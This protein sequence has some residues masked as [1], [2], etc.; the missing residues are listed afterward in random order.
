MNKHSQIGSIS[1]FFL[2]V[3]LVV[4][5]LVTWHLYFTIKLHEY[6]DSQLRAIPILNQ[7]IKPEYSVKVNP[8]NNLI[9]ITFSIPAV[10]SADNPLSGIGVKFW[11]M[12]IQAAG[13]ELIEREIN[14][15]ARER[16]N[17][18]AV[19]IPYRV[20]INT[21]SEVDI[22]TNNTQNDKT[23]T[24]LFN[25]EQAEIQQLIQEQEQELAKIIEEQNLLRQ[26]EK[27][28][29]EK[30]TDNKIKEDL[31]R[32]VTERENQPAEESIQHDIDEEL[33]VP[34]S[35]LPITAPNNNEN[36]IIAKYVARIADSV[37]QEFNSIGM[38]PGLSATV[39]IR[40]LPSGEVVESFVVKSSGNGVFDLRANNAIKKASPLPVPDDPKIHAM[41]REVRL[42]FSPN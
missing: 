41:M 21:D 2:I 27:L 37:M 39:Q 40:T 19:I 12:L 13:P 24:D 10:D 35:T 7:E 42:T 17:F 6:I 22:S 3:V 8:L 16:Y 20:R 1:H 25:K 33:S 31:S 29:Q 11:E 18:I 4:G 5:G 23:L 34:V 9:N 15:L 26:R 28:E 32:L 38:P 30:H 36:Q 14:T